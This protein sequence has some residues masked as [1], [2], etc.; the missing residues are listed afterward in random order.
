MTEI[1]QGQ[2]ADIRAIWSLDEIAQVE[3]ERCESIGV[4]VGQGAAWVAEAGASRI[5]GS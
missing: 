3:E 2:E 5:P 1:R 4:W